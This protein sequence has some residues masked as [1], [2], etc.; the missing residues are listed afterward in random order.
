[1]DTFE[2]VV[3]RTAMQDFQPV[4]LA[5]PVQKLRLC[6]LDPASLAQGGQVTIEGP[7]V[8]FQKIGPILAAAPDPEFPVNLAVGVCPD[9]QKLPQE[10]GGLR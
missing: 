5:L 4:G 1:M 3:G 6:G 9:A 7:N 8:H 2:E 10:Q